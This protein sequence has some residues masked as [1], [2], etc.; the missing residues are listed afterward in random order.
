MMANQ[1]R[2]HHRPL[3]CPTCDG[4]WAANDSVHWWQ[5]CAHL[6]TS[7][8]ASKVKLPVETAQGT[9]AL[10]STVGWINRPLCSSASC[11]FQLG[12]LTSILTIALQASLLFALLISCSTVVS[13]TVVAV[14]ATVAAVVP[15]RI[16]PQLSRQHY[17]HHQEPL[18]TLWTAVSGDE[19]Y[20]TA[21]TAAVAAAVS[22]SF[23][24]AKRRVS[25]VEIVHKEAP[26][27]SNHP[28]Y[29]NSY[30]TYS[31]KSAPFLYTVA[32]FSLFFLSQPVPPLIALNC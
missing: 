14:Q 26:N 29:M 21:P 31:G 8:N 6:R 15:E 13:G 7:M 16:S 23:P 27:F 30:L 11:S 12:W 5:C 10:F 22:S 9:R 4:H 20:S 18:P 25:P 19:A 32:P 28:M 1:H 17:N 2:Q 3:L 24:K